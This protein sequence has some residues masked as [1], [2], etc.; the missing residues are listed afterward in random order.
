MRKEKGDFRSKEQQ[1][2]LSAKELVSVTNFTL[3]EAVEML[4][5]PLGNISCYMSD[6][7]LANC[8]L[9]W[10]P[11]RGCNVSIHENSCDW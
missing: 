5:K 9:K 2:F 6:E 7:E 4:E 10:D 11:I 8:G 3:E 1:L